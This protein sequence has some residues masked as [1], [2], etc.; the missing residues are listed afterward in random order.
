MHSSKRIPYHSIN[1][2]IPDVQLP[3]ACSCTYKCDAAKR[4]P[5]LIHAN[6]SRCCPTQPCLPELGYVAELG[7]SLGSRPGCLG[8]AECVMQALTASRAQ[9]ATELERCRVAFS[10]ASTLKSPVPF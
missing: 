8:T 2:P 7:H 1:N 4:L 10:T 6:G 3:D 9:Y 5:S